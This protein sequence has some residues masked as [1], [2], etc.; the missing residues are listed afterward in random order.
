MILA[1]GQG[2]RLGVL[3]KDI[4]K[5]A[6]Q[7][8]AK[9]RIIDFALT[10]CAH[11][12]IDT[13][14]VLTQYKP[15]I[16]NTYIGSGKSWD[17]DRHNGGVY[18]L[19]PYMSEESGE[20]YKGT[21]NAIYQNMG[22]IEQF[23]PK[24]VLILSGDHV[25][26]MDYAKMLH[27]HIMNKADVTIAH[28]DVDRK[29]ASRFGILELDGER[30]VGF[31]EKPKN[32]RSNHASMGIYIFTWDKL[33]T[34]LNEDEKDEGSSNDF[35]K[36]ILPTMLHGGKR[37]YGHSFNGYW[38]D[39]GTIESLW[40][41]NMDILDDNALNLY[42]SEWQIFSKSALKPPHYLDKNALV[43][44][45]LITEGCYIDGEV[46]HSLISD[47]VKIGT[48]SIIRDSIIMSDAVIG[49]N[50]VL[51]KVIVGNNAV[52]GDNST[53]CHDPYATPDLNH[54]F[55]TD[56]ITVVGSEVII[57]GN[58]HIGANCMVTRSLPPM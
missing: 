43:N 24:Y 17:L 4:A 42:D 1:G 18:V 53:I 56:G 21:A 38:K 23:S 37:V 47:G 35:G 9:Y 6:V 41:A 58:N 20:W 51:N 13:V 2:S 39:V 55:C 27:S 49:K 30:I 50:V 16:L 5:P 45:C 33:Q 7:F 57:G 28:I 11:S 31:E 32:P 8:A 54:K 10:N 40:S 29:D 48:G 36:N 22:F 19:P 26:K 25:Y 3:T 15:L 34:A 12:G 52:I 14:G 46:V 44:N